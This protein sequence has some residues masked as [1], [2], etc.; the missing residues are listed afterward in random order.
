MT[1]D[2]NFATRIRQLEGLLEEVAAFSDV[3]AREKAGRAIRAILDF[4]AA[5]LAAIVDHLGRQGEAGRNGL[6]SLADD[7]LVSSLLLLHGLHPVNLDT[8]LRRA[9]DGVRPKLGPTA[10]RSISSGSPPTA[11][12]GSGLAGTVTAAH[13]RGP[14][15]GM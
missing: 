4:H 10:G 13:P 3:V 14:R 9:L 6:D 8:R 1:P 11:P 5:G 7:G 2:D 12:S 15:C